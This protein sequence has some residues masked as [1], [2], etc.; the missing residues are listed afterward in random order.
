MSGAIPPEELS[1]GLDVTGLDPASLGDALRAVITDALTDPLRMGTWMTSFAFAQQTVGI[2][3]LR[4]LS[5][6]AATQA[7]WGPADKRFT[8]AAWTGNPFLATLLDDYATRTK[9]ALDLVDTSRLPEATKRKARFLVTLLNDASAPSNLPWMNPAVIKEAM[10]TGGASLM[11]GAQNYLDDVAHNNGQPRQVDAAAFELGRNIA[12]TP[13]RVVFRNELIE[14]LAFAP[15]TPEVHAIPLLCSPPWINKYYIMDLAPG[16]SFIE[17]AVQHGHQTF[18][19]SYRNPDASMSAFGMDDY[20]RLGILSALDVVQEI[21]G[22]PQVNIAALCLG[23]TIATIALAYLAAIGQGDRVA[24]A[25]LTNA[26][27]DF[28]EPGDLGVFTDETTIARLERKMNERGYLD[29]KEMAG[30]FDWMRANDL[31][32]SYVVNNWFMGRKPP[33]FDILAWNGDSTRMP[34]A[35]HSQYLR[36]CYL[37]NL[38]VVPGAFTIAGVPIDLGKITTPLFVLGAENDHIAP[39]RATYLTTQHVAGESLYTR[40]NAGHIAGIV[41]PPGGKKSVH[42]TKPVEHGEDADAWLAGAQQHQGSWWQTWAIWAEDH[43]GGR[44]PALSLPDGG[45][46]APGVYVRD[47][48]AAALDPVSLRSHLQATP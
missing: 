13:G 3:F 12:C 19:I 48:V 16:R 46:P 40:T 44:V 25:T 1:Y 43:G 35:M 20:L 11:R 41:N 17:W 47:A 18:A 2:N 28:S 45:E 7:V 38:L 10:E 23:G 30:T 8:D 22:A 24:G 29:S 34:A 33:A 36:S 21:T 6:D 42:W 4:R 9:A 31:V 15:Q 37:H 26:L 14:L 5:G 32:W 27:V 39:W